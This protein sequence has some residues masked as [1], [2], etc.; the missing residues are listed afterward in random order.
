MKNKLIILLIL[1]LSIGII[2]YTFFRKDGF[3]SNLKKE[4][5]VQSLEREIRTNFSSQEAESL[6]KVEEE[7]DKESERGDNLIAKKGM[8]IEKN[9]IIFSFFALCLIA[10]FVL[11][12]LLFKSNAKENI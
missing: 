5:E 3:V 9:I 7:Y 2:L 12:K 8:A 4:K 1:F 11:S 10:Y 6:L